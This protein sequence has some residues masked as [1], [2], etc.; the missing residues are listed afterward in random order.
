MRAV[1]TILG[2]VLISMGLVTPSASADP[3]TT[4]EK[5]TKQVERFARPESDGAFHTKPRGLCVCQDG[6]ANNGHAGVLLT[7]DLNNSTDL[8]IAC[9]VRE[10][11]PDGSD[12]GAS[13]CAFF[14]VLSK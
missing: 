2:G 1:F 3:M 14:E 5:F 11:N 4:F 7:E 13:R 10:F 8:L 9:W 6:G 12:H